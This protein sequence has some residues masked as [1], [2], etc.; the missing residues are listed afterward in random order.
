MVMLE[1]ARSD[2]LRLPHAA[3]A[4]VVKMR[5]WSS[6]ITVVQFFI[7]FDEDT[8]SLFWNVEIAQFVYLDA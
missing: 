6:G 1:A 3:A 4:F 5:I 2:R 8:L 7:W